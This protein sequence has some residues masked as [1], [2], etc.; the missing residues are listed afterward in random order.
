[1]CGG[2]EVKTGGKIQRIYFPS[3]KAALPVR[4]KTGEVAWRPW[5]RRE[6]EPA[7]LPQGGWA[8]LESI[9][10]G[11]WERYAPRAVLIPV[12]RFMEKDRAGR[13]HWFDVPAD[14][15]IQGLL[16]VS[17]AEERVYV[18]TVAV[19]AEHAAIH[20]RWPR[21]VSQVRVEEKLF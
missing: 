20:D 14:A 10:N 9:K 1:M 5:G 6:S 12:Q 17:G 15:M 18:V 7:P 8:R 2:V 21:L 11:K 4:L 3:P 19:P 13:S 16:A